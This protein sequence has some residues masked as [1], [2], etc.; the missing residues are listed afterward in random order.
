MLDSD[1]GDGAGPA[2]GVEDDIPRAT[3]C[4]DAGLDK[5]LG[6]GG[7]VGP[8]VRLGG[9]CPDGATVSQLSRRCLK[10]LTSWD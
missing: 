6:E 4:Q 2:E 10:A 8:W 9:D 7:E 1:A 3:T 5:G